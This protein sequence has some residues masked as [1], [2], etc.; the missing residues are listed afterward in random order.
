MRVMTEA[1]TESKSPVAD[2]FWREAQGAKIPK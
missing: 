2:L 1:N